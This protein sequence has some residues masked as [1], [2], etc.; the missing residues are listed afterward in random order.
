M[1]ARPLGKPVHPKLFN[2]EN[3]PAENNDLATKEPER[4]AQMIGDYDR[5]FEEIMEDLQK[6]GGPPPVNPPGL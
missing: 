5:W 3:D 4:L 1:P 6:V 2:L